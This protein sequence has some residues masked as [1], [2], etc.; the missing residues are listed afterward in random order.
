MTL[1]RFRLRTMMIAVTVVA[2]VLGG[3]PEVV[4]LG[5]MSLEHRRL[6]LRC[7]R[8]EATHRAAVALYEALGRAEHEERIRE[9][10]RQSAALNAGLADHFANL[11]CEYERTTWRPWEAVRFQR[12]A[13]YHSSRVIDRPELEREM[14]AAR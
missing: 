7:A 10:C 13:R 4:R 8:T 3:G 2:T 14:G 12:L 5:R 9:A 6:A 1:S 11:R